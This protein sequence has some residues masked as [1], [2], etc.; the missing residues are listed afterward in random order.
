M[1]KK[2]TVPKVKAAKITLDEAAKATLGH[3]RTFAEVPASARSRYP[4]N[5]VD[6]GECFDIPVGS[7]SGVGKYGKKFGRTFRVVDNKNGTAT[8][9]CIEV[10]PKMCED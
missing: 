9:Y 2:P 5:T 10:T 1:A 6:A 4:W 8:V 7:R 3:V